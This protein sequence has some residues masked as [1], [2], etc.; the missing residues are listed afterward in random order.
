MVTQGEWYCLSGCFFGLFCIATGP[1]YT[2]TKMVTTIKSIIASQV[3]SQCPQEKKELWEGEFWTDE[4][5][6]STVGKHGDEDMISNYVKNQGQKYTK[7]HTD[8]QLA[9]F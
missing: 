8:H 1:T 5:L 4:Y 6:A 3:L 7:F 2:F 9:L